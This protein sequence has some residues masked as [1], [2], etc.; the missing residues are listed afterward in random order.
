MSLVASVLSLPLPPFARRRRA[1]CLLLLGTALAAGASGCSG[2]AAP[3]LSAD[4]SKKKGKR[5]KSNARSKHPTTDR[6]SDA[7][8]DSV[9]HH[10]GLRRLGPSN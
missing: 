9:P 4:A 8:R 1:A 10:H 3:G 5:A 2:P 7:L 6:H